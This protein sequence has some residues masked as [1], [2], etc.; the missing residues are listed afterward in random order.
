MIKRLS[1][2]RS[3]NHPIIR[4]ALNHGQSA[5]AYRRFMRSVRISLDQTLSAEQR[6]VHAREILRGLPD[7][8][9][10]E[11][12]MQEFLWEWLRC[13]SVELKDMVLLDACALAGLN[14]Y[15]L[16]LT[17]SQWERLNVTP[18]E[19]PQLKRSDGKSC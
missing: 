9:W 17:P 11:G 7:L 5:M 18:D 15:R 14:E 6:L 16:T 13:A 1:N 12:A 10:V 8:P 3:F 19:L 4:V 2:L